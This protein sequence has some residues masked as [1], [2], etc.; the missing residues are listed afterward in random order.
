[1][2]LF[3]GENARGVLNDIW[4]LTGANGLEEPKMLK[5]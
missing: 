2:I 3:G 5:K 4:V 1:M